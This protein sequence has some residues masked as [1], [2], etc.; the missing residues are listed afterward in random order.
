MALAQQVEAPQPTT[1]EE[2]I[3]LPDDDRRELVD[4]EL[5]EIDVPTELHEWA[6]ACLTAMLWNWARE[7]GGTTLP[8][9]YKVRITETRGVMP[10]LQYYRPGNK[11]GR[12]PTGLED[13][14]PDLAVEIVS[15]SSGRYDRV[16]KL[17]WYA[18][19]GVPEYW[20]VAPDERTLHRYVLAD[21][22]YT[23]ADAL[24]GGAVFEPDSFP[25]LRIDLA[26]LWTLPE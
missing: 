6:I 21:G 16:V 18:S 2:F 23:V 3:A 24:E 25:G 20:L 13:G 10:D 1:W 7:H 9:G 8:S 22:I 17:H 4:G 11:Q 12:K 26:E 19:L 5:R 15:P 14:A